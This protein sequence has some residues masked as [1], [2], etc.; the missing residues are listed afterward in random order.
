MEKSVS[1]TPVGIEFLKMLPF[2]SGVIVPSYSQ[3]I[4]THNNVETIKETRYCT[5]LRVSGK[6]G[7]LGYQHFATFHL[8]DTA[9][10]FFKEG[11]DITV[12]TETGET[13][14]FV[15]RPFMIAKNKQL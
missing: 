5:I 10:D 14:S 6:K 12:K 1:N 3:E 9:A 8:K 11:W 2:E 15:V 13:K 4:I 7:K